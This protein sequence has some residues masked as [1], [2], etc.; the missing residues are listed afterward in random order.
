LIEE[1][2]HHNTE[3]EEIRRSFESKVEDIRNDLEQKIC[4]RDEEIRSLNIEIQTLRDL[5]SNLNVQLNDKEKQVEY[6]N[7]EIRKLKHSKNLNEESLRYLQ[8]VLQSIQDR[9]LYRTYKV[10]SY[11]LKRMLFQYPKFFSLLLVNFVTNAYMSRWSKKSGT[12]I[13]PAQ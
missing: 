6:M 10:I 9:F 1:E 2:R 5:E 7:E 3:K 12:R 4:A 13:F 8:G 11:R